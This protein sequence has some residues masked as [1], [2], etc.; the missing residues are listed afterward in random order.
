MHYLEPDQFIGP[1]YMPELHW[2]GGYPFALALMV[3]SGL[4]LHHAF[5]R[6]GRL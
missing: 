3:A 5:K 2:A 4:A 6:R 1:N